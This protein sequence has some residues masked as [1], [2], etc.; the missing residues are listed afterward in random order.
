[1][2]KPCALLCLFLAIMVG[3][4]SESKKQ[5]N[6][7][8]IA[9]NKV[10][11][12]PIEKE[13]EPEEI[14]INYE[15]VALSDTIN[16]ISQLSNDSLQTFLILNRI[17]KGHIRSLDSVLVPDVFHEDIN[18]YC[19]FPAQVDSLKEINKIIFVSRYAQ[20]FAVYEN[21]KR[22]KWG[23]T[24]TGKEATQTPAGLFSTNW[25]RKRNIS[26]INS[27][28]I[29]NWCFNIS[30]GD[31]VSLHEFDLPGKPASHACVRLYAKD[32]EW[33]YYWA[34]QWMLNE[35]HKIIA[36]GTPVVIFGDY[37]F[38]GRKPWWN[39]SENPKALN[40]SDI[41][42]FKETK[43]FYQSIIERQKTLIWEQKKK[44]ERETKD[45]LV[46]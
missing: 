25:K 30:N 33:I 13:V 26:S 34:D 19:P 22:V 2:L 38:D 8:Q 9:Q 28:W 17:D 45:D 20:L 35:E 40:I 1:M 11:E 31:G 12:K 16:W 29:L 42:L 37:P 15:L 7:T 21:G 5:A 24:S 32:A 36:F 39:L 27:S 41:Q 3:C 18:V 43:I 46:S 23:P 10:V 14:K 4:Q 44:A 6:P